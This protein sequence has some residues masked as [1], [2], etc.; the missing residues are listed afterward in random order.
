MAAEH[1]LCRVCTWRGLEARQ[2]SNL[3]AHLAPLLRTW[4][5][6]QGL[7]GPN[8]TS[9]A[10]GSTTEGQEGGSLVPAAW[11][12]SGLWTI[13][14]GLEREV[15]V[16][17]VSRTSVPSPSVKLTVIWMR[18]RLPS[19]HSIE[20]VLHL[21]RKRSY[22]ACLWSGAD[23]SNGHNRSLFGRAT[24]HGSCRHFDGLTSSIDTTL[25]VIHWL[26]A[27]DTSGSELSL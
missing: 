3:A 4:F 5:M 19:I 13:H 11:R 26:L 23:S 27:C 17:A 2:R 21:G 16:A 14:Q 15:P 25:G 8:H 20:V 18:N 24:R 7:V 6:L 9:Q 10:A 22:D 1:V 12:L